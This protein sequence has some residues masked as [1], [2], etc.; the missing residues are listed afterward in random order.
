[1][2]SKPSFPG[3]RRK[4]RT[5]WTVKATD[6][7][8]RLFI[9]IGGLGTILA[10]TLVCVFLVY[11]VVPLFLGSSLSKPRSLDLSIEGQVPLR[12][13]LDEYRTMGWLLF[14]DGSLATIRLDNGRLLDRHRPK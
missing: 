5:H 13:G 11:E 9:T 6:W 10:I 8:A 1:M 14:Q 7:L 3:R 2:D 12:A 4:H